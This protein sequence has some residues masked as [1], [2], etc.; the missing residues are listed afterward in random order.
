MA[1]IYLRH[2]VHGEKVACSDSEAAYDKKHGWVEFDPYAPKV[3]NPVF[4]AIESEE[5]PDFLMA[6]EP[7]KRTGGRKSKE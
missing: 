5:I 1:V 6:P 2:P 4:N 7:V 3:E